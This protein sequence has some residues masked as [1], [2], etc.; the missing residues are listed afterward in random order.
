[1]MFIV[2]GKPRAPEGIVKRVEATREKALEAGMDFQ[3]DGFPFVTIVA[4]GKVYTLDEFAKTS[5]QS[6]GALN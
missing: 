6:D 1:M 4:D 2:Q 3:G 5:D